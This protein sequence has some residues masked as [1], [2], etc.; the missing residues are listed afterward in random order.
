[1]KTHGSPENRFYHT[2][3]KLSGIA[4]KAPASAAST[5]TT[6]IAMRASD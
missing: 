5:A 6:K 1:M 3:D 2:E 4:E